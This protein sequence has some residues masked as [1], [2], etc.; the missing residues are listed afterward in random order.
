MISRKLC[1]VSQGIFI[2]LYEQCGRGDLLQACSFDLYFHLVVSKRSQHTFVRNKL[3]S[4]L[5]TW[6]ANSESESV[7]LVSQSHKTS[8]VLQV[9]ADTCVLLVALENAGNLQN[10]PD[11]SILIVIAVRFEHSGC[12][13]SAVLQSYFLAGMQELELGACDLAHD[14]PCKT[15]DHAERWIVAVGDP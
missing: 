10:T 6:L 9:L 1:V 15:V 11:F 5:K 12:K 2:L 14:A 3:Q 8:G 13:G 7:I 4:I